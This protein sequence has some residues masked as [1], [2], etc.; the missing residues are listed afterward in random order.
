MINLKT[1]V[2]KAVLEMIIKSRNHNFIEGKN[3]ISSIGA[4]KKIKINGTPLD[5]VIYYY[6]HTIP[7][8]KKS[9]LDYITD[10]QYDSM[11]RENQINS[12]VDESNYIDLSSIKR[13]REKR[14]DEKYNDIQIGDFL[15]DNYRN[16]FKVVNKTELNCML[17]EIDIY[18]F[19]KN[20]IVNTGKKERSTWN[21]LTYTKIDYTRLMVIKEKQWLEAE[22]K[23]Q[24]Y[25][26]GEA[27]HNERR[28][29][30]LTEEDFNIKKAQGFWPNGSYQNYLAIQ[31]MSY[32]EWNRYCDLQSR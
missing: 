14:G 11:I 17:E 16:I 9:Y 28:K 4:I 2:G 7:G 27:E 15:Y 18:I 5:N 19:D 23:R 22:H 30:I 10:S 13:K 6:Y 3:N 25:I 26:K 20:T 32:S 8:D 24:E 12:V 29:N 21:R 31:N 1:N